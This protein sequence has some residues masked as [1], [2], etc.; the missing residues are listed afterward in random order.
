VW[1]SLPGPAEVVQR[2]A[3]AIRDGRCVVIESSVRGGRG[4]R[5]AVRNQVEDLDLQWETFTNNDLCDHDTLDAICRRLV[6]EDRERLRTISDLAHH[7]DLARKLIW[8]EVGNEVVANEAAKFFVSFAHA[9][10]DREI[11]DRPVVVLEYACDKVPSQDLRSAK[12][13]SV[14]MRGYSDW[15]D[16]RLFAAKQLR[17]RFSGHV[18]DLAAGTVASLAIFDFELVEFFVDRPFECF[19]DPGDSL[20]DYASLKGLTGDWR[21]GGCGRIGG[22]DVP[23]SALAVLEG[24]RPEVKRRLWRGQVGPLF[25]FLEERRIEL[26][27]RFRPILRV[28]FEVPV[29]DPITEIEDLEISHIK[30]LVDQSGTATREESFLLGH[31]KQLRHRLAHLEPVAPDD[32][33]KPSLRPWWGSAFS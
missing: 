24:L 4:F 9:V 33:R 16:I 28:P 17:S 23:H 30:T 29:G 12:A 22:V 2:V 18:L 20:R 8:I 14:E 26:L 3:E 19:L 11:Y 25:T 10:T 32:L 31:L 7:L 27:D 13:L 1:W 15:I 6:V 21:A 5:S